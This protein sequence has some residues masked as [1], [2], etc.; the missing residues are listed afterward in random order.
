L[1][2]CAP[3]SAIPIPYTG[4]TVSYLVLGRVEEAIETAR[5]ACAGNPR[6]YFTHQLLAA[7][8]GLK[9]DIGEAKA[10]LA[11]AFKIRPDL[12]S[13]ARLY[14]YVTWGNRRFRGLRAS[15]IDVG[16]RRAGMP[17]N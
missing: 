8:L 2:L 1:R 9:G 13:L 3:G 7:A 6:L 10:A 14:A 4:L 15:T 5:R 16:L 17:D 12:N 11:E